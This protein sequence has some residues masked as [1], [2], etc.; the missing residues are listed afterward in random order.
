MS[1]LSFLI[2][3]S[4]ALWGTNHHFETQ[5]SCGL[6]QNSP[7]MEMHVFLR[8]CPHFMPS[9]CGY[10]PPDPELKSLLGRPVGVLTVFSYSTLMSAFRNFKAWPLASRV[11]FFLLFNGNLKQEISYAFK[12][13]QMRSKQ[14]SQ[15]ILNILIFPVIWRFL[16]I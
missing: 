13:H 6:A 5:C 9:L 1:S 7:E 3:T 12:F 8:L 15:E 10:V 2:L 4:E 16:Y 11:A 14:T